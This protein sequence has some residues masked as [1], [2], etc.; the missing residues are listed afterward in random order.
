MKF[1]VPL[2]VSLAVA[3]FHTGKFRTLICEMCRSPM[4]DAG[5]VDGRLLI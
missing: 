5:F 2:F 1:L 3:S 4:M